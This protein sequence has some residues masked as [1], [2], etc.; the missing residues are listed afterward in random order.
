VL[1]ESKFKNNSEVISDGT[2]LLLQCLQKRRTVLPKRL[3][4]PGPSN[5]QK[6]LLFEA[7]ATAPDHDQILP[8]RFVIFPE[9]S[10]VALG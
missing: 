2:T 4:A 10:R 1:N 6:N 5:D 3:I 8:W 7:A 9:T